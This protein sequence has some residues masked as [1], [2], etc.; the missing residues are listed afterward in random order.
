MIT[1]IPAYSNQVKFMTESTIVRAV[2]MLNHLPIACVLALISGW[3]LFRARLY[4]ILSVTIMLGASMALAG[5]L[6]ALWLMDQNIP[7]LANRV[8]CLG[9]SLGWFISG[10][11]IV[12]LGTQQAA[13]LTGASLKAVKS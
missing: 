1:Q 3:L 2:Q 11:G 6:G 12:L 7:S 13:N 5:D 8:A 4:P 9:G 10:V